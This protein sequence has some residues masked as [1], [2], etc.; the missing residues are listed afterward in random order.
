MF[1]YIVQ[2]VKAND[3][4]DIRG[5]INCKIP[6]SI[7]VINAFLKQAED[8]NNAIKKLEVIHIKGDE[9]SLKMTLGGIKIAPKMNIVNRNLVLKIHPLLEAPDWLIKI[10]I[11]DGI[12]R[13][14]NEILEILFNTWFKNNVVD[15][16]KRV[17]YVKHTE[18]SDNKVYQ[19]FIKHLFD[20]KLI[21]EEDKIIYDLTFDFN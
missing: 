18:L 3:Y 2:Q 21:T 17:V 5:R 16:E 10:E 9:I 13:V 4:K 1:E 20:A 8:S 12:K 11:L 15:F 7:N 14:G 19:F 6:L